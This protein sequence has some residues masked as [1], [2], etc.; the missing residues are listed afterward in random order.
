MFKKVFLSTKGRDEGYK[1]PA[2]YS[3]NIPNDS[4]EISKIDKKFIEIL[5][6]FTPDYNSL[7]GEV[8]RFD[9]YDNYIENVRAFISCDVMGN[10][11]I[12]KQ[13]DL[14]ELNRFIQYEKIRNI[15]DFNNFL[16]LIGVNEEEY[17]LLV[18]S[19]IY[20]KT[21][22]YINKYKREYQNECSEL[23]KIYVSK[24]SNVNDYKIFWGES[25]HV[26]LI[27]ESYG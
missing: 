4:N 22:V 11:W 25:N 13:S 24:G 16:H 26:N 14:S 17:K 23:S 15:F 21:I 5:L 12:Y 2:N 18:D 6:N 7:K 1:I 3:I 9:T 20:E 19:D 10:N 27:L 8:K